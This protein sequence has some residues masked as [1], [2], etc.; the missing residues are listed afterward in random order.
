MSSLAEGARK[1]W[2][3]RSLIYQMT[4]R[5]LIAQHRGMLLGSVWLLL[6]PLILLGTY[7]LIFSVVFGVAPRATRGGMVSYP[8][9][10]FS[11]MTVFAFYAECLVKPS[12]Y[13][14]SNA[15]YVKKILFPTEILG[16][17]IF[18]EAFLKALIQLGLLLVFYFIVHDKIS[19]TFLLLPL[20]WLPLCMV[21]LG[22]I[23]LYAAI[24]VFVRDI[25]NLIV[26]LVTVLMLVSPVFYSIDQIPE[27]FR[28][29]Y[30]I[31][32]IAAYI[33]MTRD[34]LFWGEFPDAALYIPHTLFAMLVLWLG[35]TVFTRLSEQFADVM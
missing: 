20:I 24:G 16:V 21:L 5:E 4:K 10:I 14:K 25:H 19:W 26:S 9:L 11:G 32:P 1:I 27:G 7:T 28:A 31:N 12:T 2:I 13:L 22:T 18:G 33:E 8:L 29:F 30:L 35:H 6:M 15:S 34:V 3:H 17:V 23:W